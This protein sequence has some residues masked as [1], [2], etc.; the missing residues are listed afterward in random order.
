M[1]WSG[2]AWS[3]QLAHQHSRDDAAIGQEI[4]A[5]D[6]AGVG[7]EQVGSGNRN[8]FRWC[9]VAGGRRSDHCTVA[10]ADRRVELVLGQGRRNDARADRVDSRT[11]AP[12]LTASACTRRWL[13]RFA[14]M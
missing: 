13:A 7:P 12:Q 11:R 10:V 9:H 5:C 14:I 6:E 3:R 2:S 4:A 1:T 8:L